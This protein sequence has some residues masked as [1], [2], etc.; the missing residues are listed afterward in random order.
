MDT[1]I[2]GSSIPDLAEAE[3]RWRRDLQAARGG[4]RNALGRLL[5]THWNPLWNQAAVQ[6]DGNLRGK[7]AASDLVQETFLEA[8]RCFQ[9]FRGS[10]PIE[11]QA[12]LNTILANNI[13]DVWRKFARTQK[14]DLAIEMPLDSVERGVT[15]KS[16][17]SGSASALL[18]RQERIEHVQLILNAL[19][20]HY[21]TVIRLRHWEALTFESI[22]VRMG[23]SSDSVRQLWYR[24]IQ[25]LAKQMQADETR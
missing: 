11:L 20:S 15:K 22:A 1:N 9:S 8:Q 4:D 10:T 14:R 23:K 16:I 2:C 18:Q 24:A 19:P 17:D 21:A 13:R 7:Q 3:L 25:Q 6:I 5:Q 12:W